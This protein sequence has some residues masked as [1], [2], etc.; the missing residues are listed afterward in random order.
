MKEQH[1]EMISTTEGMKRGQNI[2]KDRTCSR[3]NEILRIKSEIEKITAQNQYQTVKKN[4]ESIESRLQN[5]EEQ[6]RRLQREL[7]EKAELI[8]TSQIK[9]EIGTRY[10]NI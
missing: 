2:Y 4:T 6:Q 10:Y 8:R 5:I 9:K 1:E 7:K 3:S